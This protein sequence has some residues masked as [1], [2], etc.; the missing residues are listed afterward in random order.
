MLVLVAAQEQE[1]DEIDLAVR[2]FQGAMLA[3]KYSP[4]PIVVAPH[5][6][7]IGGGCEINLHAARI[8]AAAEAYIG[9]V[10]TGVG[11]I[12]A[13]GG[14]KETLIRA[15]EQSFGSEDLDLFNALEAAFL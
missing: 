10:E 2:Q 8:H 5:G 15:N 9:L 13:G 12:P 1:W 4:R 11:V 7:A 14:C 3:I 6:L